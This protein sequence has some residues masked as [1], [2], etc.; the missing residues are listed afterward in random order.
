MPYLKIEE[1]NGYDDFYYKLD[2]KDKTWRGVLDQIESVLDDKYS[3][4]EDNLVGIKL[5]VEIVDVLPDD[6]E[7]GE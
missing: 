1:H 2:D 7:W 4:N 5:S 6:V 3:K